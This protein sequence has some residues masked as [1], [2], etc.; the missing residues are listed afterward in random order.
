MRIDEQTIEILSNISKLKLSA[1][2]Q[3]NMIVDLKGILNAFIAIQEIDVHNL[4]SAIL[5]IHFENCI[6]NDE[7]RVFEEDATS[8]AIYI[9]DNFIIGPRTLE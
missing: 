4:E 2:E 9:I 5:P 7:A 1:D 8:T 6:R 3:N